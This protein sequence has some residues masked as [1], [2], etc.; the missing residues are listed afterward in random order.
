MFSFST[1]EHVGDFLKVYVSM[2]GKNLA[3]M[4]KPLRE[5]SGDDVCLGV[6][7]R[8]CLLVALRTEG[9]SGGSGGSSSSQCTRNSAFSCI[10]CPV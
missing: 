9:R 4:V 2:Y 3:Q 8:Y 7:L 1:G 5:E 6:W 10:S